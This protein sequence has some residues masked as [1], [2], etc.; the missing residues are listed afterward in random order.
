LEQQKKE[1]DTKLVATQSQ[2]DQYK[3]GIVRAGLSGK[4]LAF[5][6]GWN[7]VVLSIG[8]KQG[9][10]ANTQMLVMRS[11]QPIAKVKISSVEPATSI[12][13]VIPGSLLKGESV[14]PGDT[15]VYEAKR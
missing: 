6:P 15:V 9:V 5:N 12:A 3:F 10:K 8:D 13:D 4:I 7:F 1:V 14:Q 2:V 11:G